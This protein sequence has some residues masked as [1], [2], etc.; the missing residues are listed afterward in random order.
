MLESTETVRERERESKGLEKIIVAISA[1]EKIKR[2]INLINR[3]SLLCSKT[4][5]KLAKCQYLF[6][7]MKD[8][9][10][11]VILI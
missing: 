5:K 2:N 8:C 7:Y 1:T 6:C 10:F 4:R 9:P 3:D 11:C